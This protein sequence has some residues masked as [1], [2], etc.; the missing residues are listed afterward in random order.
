MSVIGQLGLTMCGST[1]DNSD[2]GTE[3]QEG[4]MSR[5]CLLIVFSAVAGT[6]GCSTVSPVRDGVLYRSGQLSAKELESTVRK[7]DLRTVV[8]LRGKESGAQWYRDQSRVLRELNVRQ[9]DLPIGSN[10]PDSE[11]VAELLDIYRTE[12]KPILVQSKWSYGGSAGV[13]SGI[14]RAGIENESST[15]AR[16]ELAFW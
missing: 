13:A 2:D 11:V 1:T 8:N 4:G 10:A 14:Y 7:N 16:R 3:R 9:I 15:K 6:I 12:P 5:I